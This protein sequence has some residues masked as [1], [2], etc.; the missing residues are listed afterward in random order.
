MI[1]D[2]IVR[3]WVKSSSQDYRVME[4]LFNNGH[5][6]WSLFIGHL[7][8][9]KLLK[10]YLIKKKGVDVPYTHQLLKIAQMAGLTLNEDQENFLLEVTTFNIQARYPD[11]KQRFQKKAARSFTEKYILK[12]KEF[13]RWLLKEIK[14]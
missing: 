5:Y 6:G 9:E 11:Y 13:R 10:A 2:E 14:K 7:V 12:I 3:Y 1:K 4:S 8:L